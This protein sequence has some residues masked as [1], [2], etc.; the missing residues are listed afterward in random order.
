MIETMF[1]NFKSHNYCK[2]LGVF[3]FSRVIM[4]DYSK[5]G[6]VDDDKGE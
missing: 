5:F 3:L 2:N 4:K 6:F 1:L